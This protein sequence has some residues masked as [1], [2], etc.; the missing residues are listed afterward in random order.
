TSSIVLFFLLCSSC[1]TSVRQLV[2]TPRLMLHVLATPG[3]TREVAIPKPH[4]L[5]SNA[6]IS[7]HFSAPSQA[8]PTEA[9]GRVP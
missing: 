3:P 9:V 4:H 6:C 1:S 8:V 7:R 5:H 2:A